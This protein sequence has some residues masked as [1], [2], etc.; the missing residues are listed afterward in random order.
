MN[1][2]GV[3]TVTGDLI[4]SPSF[5]MNF[6]SSPRS[7]GGRLYDT[8]DATRRPA[9]AQRSWFDECQMKN[10]QACLTGAQPSVSVMGEV[11]VGSVPAGA[12]MLVTQ[13]SSQLVDILKVLLCY[14][15]NFMAE[16]L[17]EGMGGASGLQ[18]FLVREVGV[19][20]GE[21]RLSSTSGLGFNRLSP[22]SMMKV[23]VALRAELA[24][25]KLQTSDIMSVAG[26]DP[27]TLQKRYSA[28]PSRGSVVAKTGTLGHTDGGVSAL[29]GE[30]RARDGETLLFVIFN[31]RG[32]VS[33]FR[34][35]QDCLVASLQSTRGG[36]ALFDYTP[37]ALAMRLL[38]TELNARNS[39]EYEPPPNDER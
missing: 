39:S 21:V 28:S 36:P 10:D 31:R 6:S 14:S 13:H 5:T 16:R 37:H 32:N 27:G 11:Y 29:V 7:S 15:N 12:Q 35:D 38:D 9:A 24:R 1:R 33:R 17:G 23:Y 19:P 20:A 22:R 25:H 2:L 26:I 18:S 8:L 3:R 34:Q 30:F 4:V